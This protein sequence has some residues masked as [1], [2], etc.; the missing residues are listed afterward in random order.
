[1]ALPEVLSM[2]PAV[3][4]KVPVPKAAALLMSRVPAVK[5]VVPV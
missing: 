5:V 1:M 2:V 4:T 3:M